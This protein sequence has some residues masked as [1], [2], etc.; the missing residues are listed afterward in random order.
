[1]LFDSRL[2]QRKLLKSLE[3][4]LSGF[5]IHSKIFFPLQTNIHTYN[6]VKFL[7]VKKA[8]RKCDSVAPSSTEAKILY[9]Q[10]AFSW[11]RSLLGPE[12]IK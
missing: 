4:R 8:A 3:L 6:A 9:T 10:L 11:D 2:S 7:N 5:T 12:R 1:M